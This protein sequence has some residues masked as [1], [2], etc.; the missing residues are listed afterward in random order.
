MMKKG[1]NYLLSIF[2]VFLRC[3]KRKGKPQTIENGYS[4]LFLTS[5]RCHLTLNQ[6]YL[7]KSKSIV[8]RAKTDSNTHLY[9][10]NTP[11]L[12]IFSWAAFLVHQNSTWKVCELHSLIFNIR[13]SSDENSRFDYFLFQLLR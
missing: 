10:I 2:K 7:I 12:K 4:D 1:L 13:I 11:Q 5:L 3:L 8:K 6:C 9:N